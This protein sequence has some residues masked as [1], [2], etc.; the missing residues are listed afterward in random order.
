MKFNFVIISFCFFII[1][2]S[3]S[4]VAKNEASDENKTAYAN[5]MPGVLSSI[6]IMRQRINGLEDTLF[7]DEKLDF[8]K[9][10]RAI[11]LYQ[12]FV[13]NFPA[14]SLSPEYLFKAAEIADNI[15]SHEQSLLLYNNCY[16]KYKRFVFRPECIFRQGNIYQFK[17]ND[18][19]KAR[20]MYQQVID[21][22]P[23]SKMAIEAKAAMAS[24]G[25]SD[26]ELIREFE[27]KNGIKR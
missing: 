10:R 9:G 15:G 21:E 7:N 16:L 8:K 12:D 18:I 22:Y 17:V 3:C 19:S 11:R 2:S 13:D 27:K 23:Q 5:E 26:T 20:E 1:F 4:N 14:D 25:K 24:I 6:E